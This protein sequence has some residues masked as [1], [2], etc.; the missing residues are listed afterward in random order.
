MWPKSYHSTGPQSTF[1][2]HLVCHRTLSKILICKLSTYVGD[3]Q[4]MNYLYLHSNYICIVNKRNLFSLCYICKFNDITNKIQSEYQQTQSSARILYMDKFLRDVIFEVS[5]VNW[6]S[7]KFLSSKFNWKNFDLHPSESR[8]LL[9]VFT[10][11]Y[12]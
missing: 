1:L 8:I 12:Y 10:E 3:V 9:Y 6:P 11:V 2:G 4:T 7:A 5:M